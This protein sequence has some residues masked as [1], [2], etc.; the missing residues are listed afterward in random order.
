M[1][2]SPAIFFFTDAGASCAGSSSRR[3]TT[4]ARELNSFRGRSTKAAGV[5]SEGWKLLNEAME[6]AIEQTRRYPSQRQTHRSRRT[7][8]QADL[9]TTN[10]L[11]GIMAVVS[12]LEALLVIGIGVAG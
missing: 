5:A 7:T 2:G 1:A 12:V 8:W 9:G 10:L 6:T 11:L 3:S 4:Y